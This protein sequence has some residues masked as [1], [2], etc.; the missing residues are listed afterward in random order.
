[1][2][3]TFYFKSIRN[4]VV[5]F[6]SLFNNIYITR[7]DSENNEVSRI[8]VPLGYGPK[9]KYLRFATEPNS[10]DLSKAKVGYT[11]PRLAFEMTSINYD[12]MRKINSLIKHAGTIEEESTTTIERFVG[13]PYNIEFSLY[14]M[15]RNSEDGLQIIEQILPFF[16]PEFNV[17]V[18]MNSLNKKVD[19]PINITSV[20]M[21]EDYEGEM[22]QRRSITH[23]LTFSAK[24]YIF[25]PEKTYN[26]I[27]EV[28]TNIFDL[29][30]LEE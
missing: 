12:T 15:T 26:L 7:E 18:K 25:G 29:D 22:D 27:Q 30:Q 20:S 23:T 4:L 5:A 3:Q 2:F 28:Q 21:V 24:T 16:T 19:V 1:M 14:V 13:V 6:G 11:L 8:K 17:T 9:E 10:I